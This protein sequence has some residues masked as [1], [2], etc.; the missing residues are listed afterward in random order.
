ME[1][2]P[3]ACVDILVTHG[4]SEYDDLQNLLDMTSHE[5]SLHF[6]IITHVVTGSDKGQPDHA[7]FQFLDLYST[8]QILSGSIMTSSLFWN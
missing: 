1:F 4:G 8:N 7:E 3:S 5:K 2:H 6:V